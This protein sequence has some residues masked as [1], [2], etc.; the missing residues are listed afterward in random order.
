MT[1]SS[2]NHGQ[3]IKPDDYESIKSVM[4]T[5]ETLNADSHLGFGVFRILRGK[6]ENA[7]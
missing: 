4:E 1:P 2:T 5:K 7:N 6:K 3:E